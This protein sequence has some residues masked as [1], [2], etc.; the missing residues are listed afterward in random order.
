[1][2]T[3]ADL[4]DQ[5][6]GSLQVAQPRLRSY[7]GAKRFCGP[8]ATVRVHDDNT[9]VR[10]RLQ[11]LGWNRVLVVD[12]GGSETCALVGD[13]LGQL[14]QENGWA[15]IVVNG[16]IRDSAVLRTMELGVLALG[17]L[18]RKSEKRGP[19]EH[20]VAVTFAGVTFVPGH[21]LYADDDG[22]V[23]AANRLDAEAGAGN[24]MV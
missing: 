23:V 14:A 21:Y 7:G 2:W 16:C 24:A 18:P 15:G 20:D 1:M 4:C 22:I 10:L 19:G 9:S 11:E 6:G 3:T 12:G 8:I 5:Y 17:T 13:Q